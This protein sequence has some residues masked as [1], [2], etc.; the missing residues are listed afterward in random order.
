MSLDVPTQALKKYQKGESTGPGCQVLSQLI[1]PRKTDPQK[2]LMVKG[3]VLWRH[4]PK[5]WGLLPTLGLREVTQHSQLV[6]LQPA[7]N[8]ERPNSTPSALSPRQNW[9]GMGT[10]IQTLLRRD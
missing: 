7:L 8:S 6:L 10:R 1:P 2:P 4:N 3:D 9:G 5:K